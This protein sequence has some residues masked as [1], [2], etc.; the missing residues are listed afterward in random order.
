MSYIHQNFY[1]SKSLNFEK[2]KLFATFYGLKIDDAK[3][4]ELQDL[5]ET[6]KTKYAAHLTSGNSICYVS[7]VALSENFVLILLWGNY[8]GGSSAFIVE[9]PIENQ[10]TL[11]YIKGCYYCFQSTWQF[12]N[13]NLFPLKELPAPDILDKL[14]RFIDGNN[15]I[16]KKPP[17]DNDISKTIYTSETLKAELRHPFFITNFMSRSRDVTEDLKLL[18]W[19]L[20]NPKIVQQLDKKI[21]GKVPSV[22]K[23]PKFFCD[24]IAVVDLPNNDRIAVYVQNDYYRSSLV[25]KI[26][27]VASEV[28]AYTDRGRIIFDGCGNVASCEPIYFIGDPPTIPEAYE[29][30]AEYA[31]KTG[32]KRLLTPEDVKK[33]VVG[34]TARMSDAERIAQEKE[35]KKQKIDNR[36]S[37]LKKDKTLKV[38][39]ND[40]TYTR[41]V[42]EYAGQQFASSLLNI[43]EFLNNGLNGFG[44]VRWDFDTMFLTFCNSLQWKVKQVSETTAFTFTV[45]QITLNGRID[46]TETSKKISQRRL[47]LEDFRINID[48]LEQVLGQLLCFK[49]MEVC[50]GFLEQVSKCSLRIHQYLAKG[51]KVLFRDDFTGKDLCAKFTL[52]RKA[53]KHF[54]TVG[55]KNYP[56]HDINRLVTIEGIRTVDKLIDLLVN[57]KVIEVDISELGKI[58][59]EAKKAYTLAEENAKKLLRDVEQKFKLQKQRVN[60]HGVNHEGYIIHGKLRDYFIAIINGGRDDER[61]DVYDYPS[62]QHRCI[63]DKIMGHAEVGVDRLIK[64]IYGLMNDSLIADSVRTLTD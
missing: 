54:L 51:L 48:E 14:Q 39:F 59:E 61:Y 9:Q 63:V 3:V 32:H 23:G 21:L 25:Y 52:S 27:P 35:L 16:G 2:L 36:I 30:I 46:V 42:I 29:P 57:P 34:Y 13:G 40:V 10:N 24:I 8:Y 45:G 58:V 41:D 37:S 28:H 5:Y 1:H 7:D 31:K 50:M 22:R 43:P 64:R 47:Y 62:G 49:D 53:N 6:V 15:Q 12:F 17:I 38:V 11:P 20:D 18:G 55:E 60:I 4:K 44:E 56:V 33:I 19:I 26:I